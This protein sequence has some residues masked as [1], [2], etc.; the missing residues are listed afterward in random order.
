MGYNSAAIR[1][2]IAVNTLYEIQELKNL[3]NIAELLMIS[4]VTA[5]DSC[6]FAIRAGLLLRKGEIYSL[7][8]KGKTLMSQVAQIYEDALQKIRNNG[9]NRVDVE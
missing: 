8:T 5:R 9:K 6:V 1:A 4:R 7:T 3:N 2:V